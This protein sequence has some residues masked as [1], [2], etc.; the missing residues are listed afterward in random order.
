MLCVSCVDEYLAPTELEPSIFGPTSGY[1]AVEEQIPTFMEVPVTIYFP[2]IEILQQYEHTAI[3]GLEFANNVFIDAGISFVV[4]NVVVAEYDAYY[5]HE[6]DFAKYNSYTKHLSIFIMHKVSTSETSYSG[7]SW[8]TGEC[9]RF[10]AIS[11][12]INYVQ[13]FAHELGHSFGLGHVS[14]PDN[15]MNHF[16]PPDPVKLTDEQIDVLRH[17]TYEYL[18]LCEFETF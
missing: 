6:D 5:N 11:L 8:Q 15:I 1:E 18:C 4:S 13:I 3:Q 16:V 9:R 2:T 10:N 12:P 17:N 14:D 7:F